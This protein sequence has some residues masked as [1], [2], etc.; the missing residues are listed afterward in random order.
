MI[1]QTP[2]AQVEK[3]TEAFDRDIERFVFIRDDTSQLATLGLE[4][5][6]NE[7][8][9]IADLRTRYLGKK[10]ELAAAKKLIGRVAPEERAGFGQL[11]QAAEDKLKTMLDQVELS[12][13]NHI[14]RS[15]ERRVGKECRSG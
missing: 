11:V 15:E 3:I 8:R 9:A 2:Q 13:G 5:A 1:D 10:S 14:E 7:Q 6:L 4:A 12:L